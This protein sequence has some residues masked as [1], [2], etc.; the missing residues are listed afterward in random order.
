MREIKFRVWAKN[1]AN[2]NG[3]MYYPGDVVEPI[4]GNRKKES[5][6]VLT[7]HG[8]LLLQDSLLGDVSNWWARVSND[9]LDVMQYTGKKDVMK[10]DIYEGDI[11][12]FTD[13]VIKTAVVSW[14][15]RAHAF[16]LENKSYGKSH[17]KL[18][19]RGKLKIIGNIHENPELV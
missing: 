10:I 13:Y 9:S 18:T 11:V 3:K 6:F 7:Q 1:D 14:L 2:P 4:V 19:G 16:V 15:P 8:D 5:S 17:T 12:E